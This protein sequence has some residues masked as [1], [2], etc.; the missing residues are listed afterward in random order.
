[1]IRLLEHWRRIVTPIV[2][3][4]IPTPSARPSQGAAHGT[5]RADKSKQES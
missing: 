1:V 3:V 2:L 5:S 4:L